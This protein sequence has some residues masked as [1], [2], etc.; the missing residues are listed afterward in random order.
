MLRATMATVS[1]EKDV[2]ALL[3]K[4]IGRRKLGLKQAVNEV[5]RDALAPK[6]APARKPGG[7]KSQAAS[8]GH[9]EEAHELGAGVD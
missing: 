3:K 4:W 1:I 9:V 2:E 6:A 5:L 8:I 7:K